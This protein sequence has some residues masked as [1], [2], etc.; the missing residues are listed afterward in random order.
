MDPA[1][2][3][4]MFDPSVKMQGFLK[5]KEGLRVRKYPLPPGGMGN[6]VY[7]MDGDTLVDIVDSGDSC[8]PFD[9]LC[10]G[11]GNCL[12]AQATHSGFKTLTYEELI[13]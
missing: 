1:E 4:K 2:I 3:R 12:L 11:C 13:K 8:S 10:G 9:G 7:I 5:W 6:P